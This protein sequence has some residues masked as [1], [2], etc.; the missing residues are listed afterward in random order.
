MKK[1]AG[2]PGCAATV[3]AI[4]AEQHVVT[5]T[6]A[7]LDSLLHRGADIGRGKASLQLLPIRRLVAGANQSCTGFRAAEHQGLAAILRKRSRGTGAT[8][9]TLYAAIS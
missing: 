4:T 2:A 8:L 6:N 1:S 9:I 7:R 5:E 3:N